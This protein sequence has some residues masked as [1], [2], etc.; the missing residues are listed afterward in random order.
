MSVTEIRYKALGKTRVL[1]TADGRQILF[2]SRA[3]R[4][5]WL[6]AQTGRIVRASSRSAAVCKGARCEARSKNP[7]DF[8]PF[9]SP[10]YR[11]IL[12]ARLAVYRLSGN[13]GKA[14]QDGRPC[15]KP[16]GGK[17]HSGAIVPNSSGKLTP[18]SPGDSGIRGTPG[19]NLNL[20]SKGEHISA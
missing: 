19:T 9:V 20:R 3:I 18:Y 8:R 10:E 16:S 15:E 12:A 14:V 17:V 1:V 7:S 2:A 13:S 4:D 6:L 11:A 5:R